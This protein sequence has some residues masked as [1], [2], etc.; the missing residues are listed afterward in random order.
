MTGKR[1]NR[2]HPPRPENVTENP[3][4][5]A[6]VYD[7]NVGIANR[8]NG[9]W[10]LLPK[11]HEGRLFHPRMIH[12]V[13]GAGTGLAGNRDSAL[14][15]LLNYWNNFDRPLLNCFYSKTSPT[16]S[17]QVIPV[18]QQRPL[19]LRGTASPGSAGVPPASCSFGRG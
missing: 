5:T 13:V 14:G 16:R 10:S 12:P 6:R 18:I 3:A 1:A 4:G 15:T 17:L 2:F 19:L 7:K 8:F 9:T 11:G